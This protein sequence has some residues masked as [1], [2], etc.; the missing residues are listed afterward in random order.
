MRL[1]DFAEIFV[2]LPATADILAKMAHGLADDLLSTTYVAS[3]CPVLAVIAMNT[4]MYQHPATR[5]NMEI[6]Q[7]RGVHL[8]HPE[9]GYLACGVEDV[10]RLPGRERI[11]EKIAR[12]LGAGHAL[13]GKTVLVTAGP[14]REAIDPVRYLSNPS[15]G[16]MGFALARAAVRMGAERVHLVTG[17]TELETPLEVARH[18]VISAS[19][20]FEAVKPLAPSA[21]LILAA[22]AVSDFTPVEPS[23][24]KLKKSA[25][26]K[27]ITLNLKQTPD[28][29]DWVSK[30][31]KPGA[32]VVGFALETEKALEGARKKLEEKGLDFIVVNNPLEEGSGFAEET[33]RVDVLDSGGGS[34]ELPLMDKDEL[35]GRLLQLVCA[36]LEKQS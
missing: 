1:A 23:A 36:K 17:P 35:A 11:M 10:G 31:R 29:L 30:N 28:I 19:Q 15:S 2:I 18:D 25:L 26:G 27:K 13:A 7:R 6:L 8:L 22:A 20:M 4:K 14:T 33:N 9:R 16:R 32:V 3:Y 21:D 5:A 34:I 24:Q 12:I